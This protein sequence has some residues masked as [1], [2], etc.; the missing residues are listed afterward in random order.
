L[1]GNTGDRLSPAVPEIAFAVIFVSFRDVGRE[2]CIIAFSILAAVG[3][4]NRSSYFGR[5]TERAFLAGG[6]RLFDHRGV[7]GHVWAR[8]SL[9][10][11]PVEIFVSKLRGGDETAERP[12]RDLRHSEAME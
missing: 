10:N 12:P 8:R 7:I 5:D 3:G 4:R 2:L 1:I 11:I 6:I 9:Q